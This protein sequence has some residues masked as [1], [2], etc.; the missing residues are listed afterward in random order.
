MIITDVRTYVV[1]QELSGGQSFAYSQYWYNQR[2]ILL[3][4]IITDDGIFG[5]GE[6]FGP[7][8]VNKSIIE[9]V[10]KPIIIGKNPLETEVIWE[11]LYNKLRDHGQKGSPIE[12][13]SAVDIALWDIKGK[14][15]KQPVYMLLGGKFRDYVVPYATGLYRKNEP[16]TKY[17]LKEAEEYLKQGFKA[18]KLKI[19]FGVEADSELVKEIRKTIGS[20]V[21]LMVD[22]NHAYTASEA[23]KLAEKIEKY[24]IFWFEE[25]VPPENIEGYIELKAKTNIPLAGGEAE[26]TRYGFE[27]LLSR[28]AVDIAQPDCCVTG[29]IS[30]FKKIV[31]LCTINNIQCYPHIWGSSVALFTGINVSMNIP[32]F[33]PSL[34]PKP[35]LLEFDRTE[36]IFRE[37]LA[38]NMPELQDGKIYPNENEGLGIEI[39]REL[40]EKYRID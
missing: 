7:A 24:D 37:R 3:V 6:A 5:W 32:H 40:I 27:R 10:Y 38:L 20:N 2:T 8:F 12:A 9:T 30:E 1:S 26:F 22:A 4:E 35:M 23:L 14:Y 36:N 25:P 33:P 11:E 16:G 34:T 13:L 18:I 19:G 29:G 15:L 17:L 31:T 28:R 39:D 21:L